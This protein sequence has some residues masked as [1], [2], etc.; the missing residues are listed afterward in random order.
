MSFRLRLSKLD[1]NCDHCNEIDISRPMLQIES[2]CKE[3][4]RVVTWVHVD[5]F[6]RALARVKAKY[7]KELREASC[8]K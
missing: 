1:E 4:G 5:E 3:T 2:C 6:E 7:A 8:P